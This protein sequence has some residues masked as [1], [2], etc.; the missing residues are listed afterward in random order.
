MQI[1]AEL[2]AGAISNQSKE[3]IFRL[4]AWSP[5]C[6][7]L[8]RNQKDD[9]LTAYESYEMPE[10]TQISQNE[11]R[12]KISVSDFYFDGHFAN[13]PVVPGFMQFKFVGICAEKLGIN[14]KNISHISSIKFMHFIRPNDEIR[15]FIEQNGNKISFKIQTEKECCNGK[16]SL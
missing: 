7:S 3:A 16:I 11:F 4:Y 15:L 10:F 9:F 5:K 14:L 13:F 6:I 12:A 2:L 8:G 1:D